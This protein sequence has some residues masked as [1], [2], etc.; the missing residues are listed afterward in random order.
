MWLVTLS[1]FWFFY[2]VLEPY[3]LKIIGQL[4]GVAMIVSLIVTPLVR[5]TR[6]VLQPARPQ[7]INTM[8]ATLSFGMMRPK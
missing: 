4:L 6:F 1:I 3:G 2:R 8:R 7:E 5:L